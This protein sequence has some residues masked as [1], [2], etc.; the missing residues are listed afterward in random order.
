[1]SLQM[2]LVLLFS[3]FMEEVVNSHDIKGI[4]HLLFSHPS[5]I[6]SHGLHS[7][8]TFEHGVLVKIHISQDFPT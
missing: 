6:S 3:A 7:V 1:M 2:S 4:D 8:L 5:S